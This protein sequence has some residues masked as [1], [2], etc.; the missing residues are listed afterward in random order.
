VYLFQQGLLAHLEEP[1][2]GAS[3]GGKRDERR[4]QRHFRNS[5]SLS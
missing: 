1:L 5:L 4:L 2:V 3:L